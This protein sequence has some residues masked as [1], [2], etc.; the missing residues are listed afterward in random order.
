[1]I[2]RVGGLTFGALLALAWL[3]QCGS[4]MQLRKV[5]GYY[6]CVRPEGVRESI[7][8]SGYGWIAWVRGRDQQ[9][10]EFELKGE[11]LMRIATVEEPNLGQDFSFTRQ[12][13]ELYL[14]PKLG[15]SKCE[16]WVHRRAPSKETPES[17]PDPLQ[18]SYVGGTDL[19]GHTRP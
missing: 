5:T 18:L 10:F 11:D 16:R 12:G 9:Q 4:F 1:M 14:T 7:T 17:V 2:G 19:F 8:I 3:P 13:D 15:D 6:E